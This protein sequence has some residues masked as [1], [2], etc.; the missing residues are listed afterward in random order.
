MTDRLAV[1]YGLIALLV[2]WTAILLWRLWAASPRRLSRK[3]AE[4]YWLEEAAWQEK[5]RIADKA[6]ETPEGPEA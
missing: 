6:A 3:R 5:Q 4:A 2:I 1:A